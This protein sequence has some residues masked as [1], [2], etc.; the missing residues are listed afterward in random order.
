MRLL[1]YVLLTLFVSV[2]FLLAEVKIIGLKGL[3]YEKPAKGGL[4]LLKLGDIVRDGHYIISK[5]NSSAV[6]SFTDTGSTV[7]ISANSKMRIYSQPI[8]AKKKNK[9]T[10]G[11]MWGKIKLKVKKL[12]KAE[13]D[14]NVATPVTILAVR[15]TEFSASVAADGSSHVVVDEGVVDAGIEKST[16]LKTGDKAQ[17]QTSK[18]GKVEKTSYKSGDKFLSRQNRAVR[19]NPQKS[20]ESMQRYY[21]T[22]EDYVTG[23]SYK[24]EKENKKE[25]HEIDAD[26]SQRL[27][28]EYLFAETANEAMFESSD[29]VLD[30]AK[31]DKLI[32]DPESI[33]EKIGGLN[34]KITKTLDRIDAAFARLDERLDKARKGLDDRMKKSK[35]RL[36]SR[37][38]DKFEKKFD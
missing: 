18:M 29:K 16:R 13:T 6:L 4:N 33:Q 15:G 11:L 17:S 38:D 19:D 10:L 7:A 36:K 22:L 25:D 35:D 21:E 9:T 1:K 28:N 26:N 3:V 34:K 8:K 14:F 31:E 24:V 5:E 37:F 27:A 30:E 32:D 20:L 12:K 2:S 23:L